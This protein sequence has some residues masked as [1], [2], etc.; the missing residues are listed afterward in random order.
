MLFYSTDTTVIVE[1]GTTDMKIRRLMTNWS[2]AIIPV[3]QIETR[4]VEATI[5]TVFIMV[6][7]DENKNLS[8]AYARGTR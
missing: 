1:K 7:D 8:S 6:S 4:N 2:T 3:R 5:L